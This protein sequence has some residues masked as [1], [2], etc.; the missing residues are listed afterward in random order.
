MRTLN[1][2]QPLNY[3]GDSKLQEKICHLT[4]HLKITST[5]KIYSIYCQKHISSISVSEVMFFLR[6]ST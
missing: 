1:V 4:C 5:L 3:L 6:D 2:A